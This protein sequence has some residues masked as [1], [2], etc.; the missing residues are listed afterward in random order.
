MRAR[1]SCT[2]RP[3]TAP[4]TSTPASRYGLDI[5]TPVNHR[6]EFTDDVPLWAGMHVFKANPLIIEL[7]RERG[8]LLFAE[9]ITHSYPHCWRCKNPVIFR[10]TEQWFISMDDKGLREKALE[11]IHHVVKWF[12]RWGEERMAGMVENRPDWCISRQ[13]LWGVPITALY[14]DKCNEPVTSPEF[15]EKSRRCF[16]A[17]ARM[18]GT[19]TRSASSCRPISDANA[20][21]RPSG[22][23]PTFSMS[24]STRAARISRFLKK[25]PELTW[26]AAVYLEGHDQHRGW[27]QSSLL[28][29][30][31]LEGRAP[32][33]QVVTC[34]FIV[35][36]QGDKMSKSRGNALSPQDVIKRSGADI[37][38]LWVSMIDYRDDMAWGDQ[39]LGRAAESY[40]KIR[41]TAR[42]LI[43]NLYDFDPPRDAVPVDQLS[44]DRSL[45]GV[46]RRGSPSIAVAA[47]TRSTSSTSSITASSISAPSICRRSISTSRR[48]RCTAKRPRR[49][50]RS[51]QTAMFHI[52]R[53]IVGVIAPILSF[54]AEEIYEAIPG[55]KEASVHLTDLPVLDRPAIDEAAWARVLRVREAVSKVLEQARG[56]GEIG[57]S[58]QADVRLSGVTPQWLLGDLNL[59]LA[60]V[61][62]VSHVDFDPAASGQ[63]FEI[64]GQAIGIQ[65]IPARGK[66]CGRCWQY[67]E[68]VAHEGDLC[69]RCEGVVASLA[70]AEVPTT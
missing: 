36:E 41:N 25:R 35:N 44:G 13:R 21:A 62:I 34:G 38:R 55:S 68:E 53:G 48:T 69:A 18:R 66:K 63:P 31:A 46:A 28:V 5:Y 10:A 70:P 23:R 40:R 32:Y 22:K 3:A 50:R 54:T 47:R 57:Q 24:G 4:T 59:D 26:P 7:L 39:I 8:A 61:F 65:W 58:L 15:F 33:E 30:T 2:P 27:F 6:G 9:T 52:L 64:D 12:P 56:A 60:K 67:R 29:G 51:A 14:C 16:V 19:S 45:G 42:F 49:E 1:D 11:Q 37:L 20:A 43:S 17:K